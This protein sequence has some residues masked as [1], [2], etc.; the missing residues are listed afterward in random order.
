MGAIDAGVLEDLPDGGRCQLVPQAGQLAL[1][2]PA[3]KDGL[4]RAISSTST[5]M[6]SAIL[7]RP[8]VR[9]GQ[10]QRRRTR[11]ARQRSKVRGEMIRRNWQRWLP[12]RL[13]ARPGAMT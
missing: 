4:S 2:A 3:P 1:D 11:S 6:G 13:R 12:G 9:R 5:R 10:A 7:G 8:G